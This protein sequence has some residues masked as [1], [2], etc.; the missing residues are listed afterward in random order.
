[1]KTQAITAA[2]ELNLSEAVALLDRANVYVGV[3]SGPMHIAAFTGTPVVALF[4]PT[5][6]DKVGPYGQGHKVIT[7]D[8]LDC[9]GCRKRQCSDR[10]C[11]ENLSTTTVYTAILGQL[12]L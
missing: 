6:P 9:L 12:G 10:K 3:D 8:D 1:M 7:L 5:E 11:L 2:G 4:G